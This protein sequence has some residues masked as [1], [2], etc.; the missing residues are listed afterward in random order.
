MATRAMNP[1]LSTRRLALTAAALLAVAALAALAIALI[2][3]QHLH[4]TAANQARAVLTR[5]QA[6]VRAMLE[7]RSE[8]LLIAI[9]L[10]A[11]DPRFAEALGHGD[12]TA[13]ASRL[14]EHA[15][16]VDAD[17]AWWLPVDAP[18]LPGTAPSPGV[19]EDPHS[20]AGHV[21]LRHGERLLQVAFAEISMGER[22]GRIALGLALDRALEGRLSELTGLRVEFIDA[23]T[24]PEAGFAEARIPLAGGTAAVRLRSN[25]EAMAESLRV[26]ERWLAAAAALALLA[27]VALAWLLAASHTGPIAASGAPAR[28][29][30]RGRSSVL[31]FALEADPIA[32]PAGNDR[33]RPATQRDERSGQSPSAD[34]GVD[35][36]DPVKFLDRLEAMLPSERRPVAVLVCELPQLKEIAASLG[37][38][39]AERALL[40]S[41]ARLFAATGREAMLARVGEQRLALGLR[42]GGEDEALMLAARVLAALHDPLVVD[43]SALW[44]EG[45]IGLAIAPLHGDRGAALL[46]RADAAL[47]AAAAL[48][49]RIAVYRPGME[50]AR[51]RSLA[52]LSALPAAIERGVLELHFQ[53]Q[54]ALADHRVLAAEGL[55]RWRDESLG[56]IPPA[57]F[58]PLAEQ[59][60]LMPAITRKVLGLG[61]AALERWDRQGVTA[62]LALN[63]S[64]LDLLDQSLPATIRA[65]LAHHAVSPSRITVEITESAAVVDPARSRRVF[66]RLK[67]LGLRVAIDDF[68]TGHSSLAVLGELPVDELKLEASHVRRLATGGARAEA[69]ARATIELARR[70]SLRVVA[71]G[72]EDASTL[73]R[74]VALGCDTA[75]GWLIAPAMAA[76]AFAEWWVHH[77]RRWRPPAALTPSP[78]PAP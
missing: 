7:Q 73:A 19:F 72:V 12:R 64:A 46:R 54:L 61:V 76:P 33:A 51:R 49:E 24:P 3:R 14:H 4:Q 23:T 45:R 39:T 16:L 67:E 56:T 21:V 36:A 30:A 13:M 66:T 2:A 27:V 63:L 17:A 53:P 50:E 42:T 32:A 41:A 34:P 9:R 62:D 52:L 15:A 26:P 20:P 35:L 11:A 43:G 78:A 6:L 29:A 68:G 5:G 77:G 75:Q 31:A 55:L 71:E 25:P 69:I 38:E 59:S 60:G 74:L 18:P 65:L 28:P 48:P 47:A 57:E 37:P 1:N 44:V 8:R 22:R 70:L 10:L 40:I 58:V